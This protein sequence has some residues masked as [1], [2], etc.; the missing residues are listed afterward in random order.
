MLEV[1]AVALAPGVGPGAAVVLERGFEA[2]LVVVVVGGL[3]VV[4]MVVII[5][6]VVV[7]VVANSYGSVSERAP[8]PTHI[9]G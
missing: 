7:V 1:S 3:G 6:V 4:T 5:V 8:S 9:F 2:P